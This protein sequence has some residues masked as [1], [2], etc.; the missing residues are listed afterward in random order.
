MTEVLFE[1]LALDCRVDAYGAVRYF[2]ALGQ[3]HRVYGPAIE[4]PNRRREW[5]QNGQRH[6]VDGPAVEYA[7]GYREWWQHGRL[8][9]LDGPA[10]ERPDGSCEWY[11]DDSEL[12]QA[13]WQQ[14]VA[15]MESV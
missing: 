10:I 14:A 6:R 5:Y 13:Q 8:H 4:Y 15:S 2:N 7:D 12:T 3:R 11:I 9:R 1:T